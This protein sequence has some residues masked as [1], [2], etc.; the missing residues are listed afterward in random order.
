MHLAQASLLAF[1]ILIRIKYGDSHY[2]TTEGI[3]PMQQPWEKSRRC[4]VALLDP[5]KVRSNSISL[6]TNTLA[7]LLDSQD[8]SQTQ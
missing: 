1:V 6:H 3:Q 8:H 7:R 2:R 4:R 5:G